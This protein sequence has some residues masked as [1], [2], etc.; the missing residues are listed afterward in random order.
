MDDVHMQAVGPV[1][2]TSLL[3]GTGLKDLIS[4]EVQSDPNNPANPEAQM[5]YNM[6]A[7][8]VCPYASDPSYHPS[9][10]PHGPSR[11]L[12]CMPCCLPT[13]HVISV[14]HCCQSMHTT[15]CC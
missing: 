11:A 6:A 13:M 10:H 2:V 7:I 9:Y 14:R 3:L 5:E 15:D 1:A 4:S 8:Q 12:S